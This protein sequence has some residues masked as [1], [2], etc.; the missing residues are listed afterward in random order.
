MREPDVRRRGAVSRVILDTRVRVGDE[1]GGGPPLG[2]KQRGPSA[3]R[4][5]PE[6][7]GSSVLA[8]SPARN[9]PLGV[10]TALKSRWDGR[11]RIWTAARL[12]PPP[13]TSGGPLRTLARAGREGHDSPTAPHRPLPFL[14][15]P[16]PRGRHASVGSPLP[17][18]SSLSPRVLRPSA[19]QP[20]SGPAGRPGPG[21]LP[22][23]E[24]SWSGW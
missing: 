16:L 22:R 14:S 6:I 3:W 8:A 9:E 10:I 18:E 2:G 17:P 15:P 4:R 21:V 20:P 11:W 13:G 24:F 12:S 1:G 23:M 19:L 7:S 5:W